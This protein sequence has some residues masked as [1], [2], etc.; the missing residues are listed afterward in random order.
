MY[1]QVDQRSPAP[2]LSSRR[3]RQ[4]QHPQQHRR[5]HQRPNLQLR[6]VLRLHAGWG[7]SLPLHQLRRGPP[8]PMGGLRRLFPSPHPIPFR[9]Q[10]GPLPRPPRWP[11]RPCPR[12]P[13]QAR[14]EVEP[15]LPPRAWD[16]AG[17]RPALLLRAFHRQGRDP[18]PLHGR[19]A[20]GHR[21]GAAHVRGRRASLPPVASV[22]AG[23]RVA[24]VARCRVREARVG[25][26]C[27]RLPLRSVP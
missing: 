22:P 20:G 6:R 11:L 27:H 4:Q 16:G 24:G 25:P 14:A 19:R 26:T 3:H 17:S 13:Q 23:V 21:H 10:K 18:L 15:R 12:P 7:P 5:H 8:A 1:M 9:P 2:E